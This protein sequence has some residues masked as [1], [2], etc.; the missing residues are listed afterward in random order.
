M[1]SLSDSNLVPRPGESVAEARRGGAPPPLLALERCQCVK[2]RMH[3]TVRGKRAT[4]ERECVVCSLLWRDVE[5]VFIELLQALQALFSLASLSYVASADDAARGVDELAELERQTEALAARVARAQPL[6]EVLV[7]WSPLLAKRW[8]VP[9]SERIAAQLLSL[10]R[11]KQLILTDWHRIGSNLPEDL[12]LVAKRHELS[13]INDFELI[14]PISRGAFGRVFLSR[15]TT[16]RTIY[17]AKVLEKEDMARRNQMTN[18]RREQN[19]MAY[20]ESKFAVQLHYAFQS[21]SYVFLLME[22]EPGGDLETMLENVGCISSKWVLPYLGEMTLAIEFIHGLGIIHRDIKPANWLLT[23]TGHLKLADFGL[24]RD[25]VTERRRKKMPI[26]GAPIDAASATPAPEAWDMTGFLGLQELVGPIAAKRSF[27]RHASRQFE[28]VGTPG[29][30]AP[31]LLQ[32]SGYGFEVDWWSLGITAYEMIAGLPPFMG[33]NFEQILAATLLG[34][35]D[36]TLF[37]EE[38]P[39]TLVELVRA[40]LRVA[41]EERLGT[42]G[43]ADVKAHP[44]FDGL[45]WDNLGLSPGPFVPK[46]SDETDTDYFKNY[47]QE[48]LEEVRGVLDA[49]DAERGGGGGDQSSYLFDSID[50]L[51]VAEESSTTFSSF[52]EKERLGG[53]GGGGGNA[54]RASHSSLAV[55]SWRNLSALFHS[56]YAALERYVAGRVLI[57]PAPVADAGSL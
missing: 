6:Y 51:E 50:A 10:V 20:A 26:S 1:A 39:T 3:S 8:R 37:P 4:G 13:S 18:V 21:R 19:I 25:G 57:V 41:P 27:R 42:R 34:E 30:A 5:R 46:L 16:T 7:Q 22:Y 54:R 32:E 33:N 55:P 40:L 14:K 44:F 43:A 24:S 17:A 47:R 28:A 15:H 23:R 49:I 31:E 9:T 35:I 52:S 12:P 48:T 36:F 56:N 45:D 29:Y 2:G 11:E 53:G 38:A